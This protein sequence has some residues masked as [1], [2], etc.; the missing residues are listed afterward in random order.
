M[1]NLDLQFWEQLAARHEAE[2]TK[3]WGGS[4][5]DTRELV[6]WKDVVPYKHL[7]RCSRLKAGM[8][9]CLGALDCLEKPLV[10][11]AAGKHDACSKHASSC[12]YCKEENAAQGS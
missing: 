7:V 10:K 1:G 12:F 5:S 3:I 2:W 9:I 11:C 6:Y 8:P 4:A